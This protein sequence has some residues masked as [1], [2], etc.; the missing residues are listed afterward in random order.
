MTAVW[1]GPGFFGLSSEGGGMTTA[2]SPPTATEGHQTGRA[3]AIASS[4]KT[5]RTVAFM[6]RTCDLDVRQ[7][8]VNCI[9]AQAHGSWSPVLRHVSTVPAVANWS[10]LCSDSS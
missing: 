2:L 4:T 8:R 6:T 9:V 5:E 3:A 10:A 1:T 7:N